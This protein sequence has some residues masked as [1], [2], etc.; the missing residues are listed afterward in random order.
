[1]TAIL[2]AILSLFLDSIYIASPQPAPLPPNPPHAA[3]FKSGEQTSGSNRICHYRCLNGSFS[4]TV[5]ISEF[6][7]LSVDR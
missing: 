2:A 5:P 3:C 1:M 4:I 6:C 7:P